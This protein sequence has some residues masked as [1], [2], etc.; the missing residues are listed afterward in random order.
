MAGKRGN[1]EGTIYQRKDGRWVAKY[2]TGFHPAT[3]KQVQKSIY[4]KTRSEVSR[5]LREVVK[6][7]DDGS[8]VQPNQWTLSQWLETWQRDYLND[9]KPYT[10]KSYE[11]QARVHIIPAL[12]RNKLMAITAPMLQR[13]YNDLFEGQKDKPG[14]SAKTVRNIHGVLHRALKQAVAIGLLRVNPADACTMPRV[15]KKEIMPM[16]EAQMKRFLEAIKGHRLEN[17]YKVDL[18]TGMRQGELLALQWN[19]IDFERGTITIDRQLQREKSKGGKYYLAPLKNNK[20]RILVSPAIVM[21]ALKDERRKQ[22]EHRLVAGTA[23][24]EGAFMDFVFTNALGGHLAIF[25]SYIEFKRI[26]RAAGMPEVRFHDLRHTYATSA[27]RSG[28]DI[29]SVQ[30]D[31]GH[32]SAAFTMDTYAHVTESMKRVNA[33]RMQAFIMGLTK[34]Q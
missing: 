33:D 3:G 25:T 1:G 27:L 2:T 21:A 8:Y 31:L 11:T 19:R 28:N 10:K 17:L 9:V 22:L 18:F 6:S 15:V 4:G 24:D 23:W 34:D 26:V 7:I 14:L 32:H 20:P 5:K 12:G 16:D 29:K 13:F 30:E